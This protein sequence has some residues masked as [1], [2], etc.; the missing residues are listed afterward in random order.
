M[1]ALFGSGLN[2]PVDSLTGELITLQ[3]KTG[4]EIIS[5]DMPSGMVADESSKDNII[6]K[7]TH[8]LTF[9]AFKLALL[10]PENEEFFG[11]I[12]VLDIGLSP[13]FLQTTNTV[14]ELLEE[15]F[16]KSLYKPRKSFGHKGTYGHALL[17]TGSYGKM[18]AG[19]LSSTA[20]LRSGV[21]LL[22]VVIPSCGY[23][24][25]QVSVPEA[26][27]IPAKE[28]FYV[29]PVDADL[30]K[31]NVIGIGPGLGTEAVLFRAVDQLLSNY[32][33]PLVID[34]D[35]LNILS[36]HKELFEKVPPLSILTPHPKEFERLFGK[37]PNDF[38]RLQLL[39][40]KKPVNST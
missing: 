30:S 19:V 25:M 28:E 4:N 36:A 13:S 8:T 1:D 15:P 6:I 34:A 29:S 38:E 35:A 32:R 21:G 40:V 24:I 39:Q 16:I 2:R 37:S 17:V 31:Y 23:N 26:M 11:E 10:V 5:I 22:S 7:A 3:N 14:T 18:G 12:H 9:Q 20:C 33:S 27:V